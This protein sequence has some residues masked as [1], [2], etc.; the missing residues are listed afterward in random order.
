MDKTYQK[1]VGFY[2]LPM[3]EDSEKLAESVEVYVKRIMEENQIEKE[4]SEAVE[5]YRRFAALRELILFFRF[6]DLQDKEPLCS[7]CLSETVGFVLVPC[8]H[9]LCGGC[10]KRQTLSCYMCRTAVR[11]KVKLYFG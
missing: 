1:V 2:E 7:I 4:Y 9:T 6:T 5:A 8:G 10:L 11:E 3:N